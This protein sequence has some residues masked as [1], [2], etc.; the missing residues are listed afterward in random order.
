[1]KRK[2]ALGCAATLIGCIV[3]CAVL[4][5]AAFRGLYHNDICAQDKQIRKDKEKAE[6]LYG[7]VFPSSTQFE[8]KRSW[9]GLREAEEDLKIS[10]REEDL[11]AFKR[12]VSL[13]Q[14]MELQEPRL[15]KPREK[16]D[17]VWDCSAE[18]IANVI[19]GKRTGKTGLIEIA[20]TKS[21]NQHATAY[22]VWWDPID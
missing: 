10:I 5:I 1:M 13:E 7:V 6:K 14:R 8:F 12:S 21:T 4:C 17:P 22:L 16:D 9:G 3:L 11:D 15:S 2:I 18:H 20:I 19:Q